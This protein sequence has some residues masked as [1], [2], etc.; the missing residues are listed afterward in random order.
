MVITLPSNQWVDIYATTGKHRHLKLKVQNQNNSI[1]YAS[2]ES[3][4]PLVTDIG[5]VVPA[6]D[7]SETYVE[8]LW[9]KSVDE[10][11]TIAIIEDITANS[12]TV[13]DS[14]VRFV[15]QRSVSANVLTPILTLKN[16]TTFNSQPNYKK[17][18]YATVSL[19]VDGTKPVYW[20]VIK[21]GTLT[22]ASY[23]DQDTA[24]SI[25]QYDV[26]ATVISAGSLVGGVVLGKTD[27]TRINLLDGDIVLR[28]SPGETITLAAKSANATVVD[29]FLRWIEEI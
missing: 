19:A 14:I 5:E 27:S 24:N 13:D 4:Q 17:V 16:K 20:Q 11:S 1:L 10:A 22:G 28:I 25:A 29:L 7:Y 2:S 3:T 8:N 21:N 12:S 18:V 6:L 26:S 9:V 15:E 23:V